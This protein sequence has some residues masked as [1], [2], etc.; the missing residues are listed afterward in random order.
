[1]SW[2]YEKIWNYAENIAIV[3]DGKNYSYNN[4]SSQID[5]YYLIIKEKIRKG[6]VIAILSDYSFHSLAMFFALQKNKNVI[7]P[8]TTKTISEVDNR[9]S[10]SN[11]NQKI[12]IVDGKIKITELNSTNESHILVKNLI[13]KN[14]S[15]LILFSSGSTGKPKAMIHDLDNLINSYKERKNKKL[16]FLV[17]LMFDH[18]GGLNT[19]LNCISMGAT[20]VLPASRDPEI[21]CKLI[22]V[23]KI[24]ILP[25]SPTFLNMI[26]MSEVYKKHNLSSLKL[27]TYGTEP[28]PE[29]LLLK[30]K[31][32]LPSAKFLQT[33]GTS[34]TGIMQVKSKSSS[35]TLLK[36]DDPNTEHKIVNGELWIRSKTQV[37]GYLN[38]SMDGF[39]D[40]GWFMT[41]DLVKV[42]GDYI[43]I[44]GRKSDIIN[45]GGE[46]VHPAEIESIILELDNVAE[47]TV[48]GEKNSIMGNIVCA[49]VKLVKEEDKKEFKLRLKSYCSQKMQSFKVPVRIVIDQKQQFN[50]R[51][52]KIRV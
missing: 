12:I 15:G 30:L 35:S 17:F 25:A 22:E 9:L 3:F 14:K 19:M 48:F 2:I 51:F 37:L 38:Y 10:I 33:F 4:L 7:V 39:T 20:L 31:S 11:C 16:V 41:N 40:D 1:M 5:D 26:L 21:I 42:E 47:V 29:S 50:D 43:K 46:K 28:M 27:V 52:K 18:I 23:N 36:F 34:E 24:N 32:I 13:I 45:V 6:Q 44:L 49:K 8:I